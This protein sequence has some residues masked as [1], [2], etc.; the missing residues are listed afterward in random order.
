MNVVLNISNYIIKL[1]DIHIDISWLVFFNFLQKNCSC[2]LF[3][4]VLRS[5]YQYLTLRNNNNVSE[6][7]IPMNF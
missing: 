2:L 5:L 4:P 3:A 7:K 6:G 1:F